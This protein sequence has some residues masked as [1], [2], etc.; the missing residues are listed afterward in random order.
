MIRLFR[1]YIP[2]WSL[3]LALIELLILVLSIY[4]GI[5]LR[6][7]IYF[8][9]APYLRGSDYIAGPYLPK[10][11]VFAAVML[12][13]ML[14]AGLYQY[15][16]DIRGGVRGMELRIALSFLAGGM[17]MMLVFYLFPSLFLGRGV[18]AL[19]FASAF[20]GVVTAR[21]ITFRLA[22]TERLKPCIIVLGTGS[23]AKQIADLEI[24]KKSPDFAVIGYVPLPGEHSVI[25]QDRTIPATGSLL[26]LAE[27]CGADELVIAA[28][29]R[30][31]TLP[32]SEILDCK[33]SGL[34]VS[35]VL[36][37][38]ERYKGQIRLNDLHPSWLI[39]SDGFMQNP[40][41]LVSKRV[42]D[43]VAS[44]ALLLVTAPVMLMAAAAIFIESGGREPIIY[45]QTRVG[46][47]SKP[48]RL[49][50]FRSMVV[51]AEQDGV[52]Q[53][54]QKGDSRVTRVGGFMRKTRIDEL[55]QIFNVLKGDMSFVGPRPERPEFVEMLSKKIPF[56]LARHRVK[57]G[58]TGWAQILLSV[59]GFRGGCRPEDAV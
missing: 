2:R 49:M 52:A 1:H 41:R 4:L 5:Y 23:A 16:P 6:E 46:Q 37:F 13:C 25:A 24:E 32:V 10:A 28:S 29:E 55:P 14:V 38:F 26:D 40:I 51:D 45:R 3:P 43:L 35:D 54:A 44:S 17:I 18:M 20:A 31:K 30:R 8:G 39:F 47:G 53:W 56:Y 59:W 9:P 34:A 11:G 57:P 48:F 50:K 7:S 19:A 58:I 42:F 36:L 22:E 21:A 12:L 27:R 33:M 15:Q